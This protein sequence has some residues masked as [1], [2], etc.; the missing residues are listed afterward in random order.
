[1]ADCKW[2]STCAHLDINDMDILFELHILCAQ[3]VKIADLNSA[4]FA[5]KKFSFL[6]LILKSV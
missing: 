3:I 1:M 5:Y 4:D 2:P 6:S